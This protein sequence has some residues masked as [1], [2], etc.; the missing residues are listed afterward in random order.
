MLMDTRVIAAT[1]TG[2]AALQVLAQRHEVMWRDGSAVQLHPVHSFGQP[3]CMLR[4]LQIDAGELVVVD[5][6]RLVR[7]LDGELRCAAERDH[8]GIVY[9]TL[10]AHYTSARAFVAAADAAAQQRWQRRDDV[11]L[12]QPPHRGVSPQTLAECRTMLAGFAA[13]AGGVA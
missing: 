3:M 11:W 10:R 7:A 5:V 2:R 1:G 12:W 9:Y 8:V 13:L 4:G 6:T